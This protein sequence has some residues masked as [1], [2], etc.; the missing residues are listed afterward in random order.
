MYKIN[1]IFYSLQ[2]E[3]QFS[4]FPVV[5]IRFSGCNRKCSWCDTSFDS[6]TEM[7]LNEIINEINKYPTKRIVL[8]GGEP[9][10]QTDLQLVNALHDNNKIIHIESNGTNEIS[11]PIDWVTIS[12]KDDSWIQKNGNELKVVY[13]GQDLKQYENNDIH[14]DFYYLQPC[15]M[16][17]TEEVIKIC[18]ENPLWNLSLQT[19]KI[20]KIQ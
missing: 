9:T 12:P 14:F 5:F 8:T 6:F 15:S 1:E 3:G 4:G 19:Q 2:G 10:L 11:L 20:L 16:L 18:K 17:N 13:T 7:S